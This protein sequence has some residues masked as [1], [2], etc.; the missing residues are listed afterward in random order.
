MMSGYDAVMLAGKP[1]AGAAEPGDDLVHD[2]EHAISVANLPYAAE[3]LRR[4]VL[5]P[6]RL[7]DRFG[8]E[9]GDVLRPFVLDL[10]LQIVGAEGEIRFLLHAEGVAVAAGT[11]DEGVARNARLRDVARAKPIR[12]ADGAHGC[13]V[14][15]VPAGDDLVGAR[16][17]GLGMVLLRQLDGGFHRLGTAGDEEHLRQPF[18]CQFGDLGRE[19]DRRRGEVVDGAHIVELLELPGHRGGDLRVAVP[20]RVGAGV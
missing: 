13:P 16:F 20:E 6:V 9:G 2:Q 1:G 7:H 18:R 15:G 10:P 4:W 11:G 12:R 8:D 3:I 14:V 5:H 19:L 17:A